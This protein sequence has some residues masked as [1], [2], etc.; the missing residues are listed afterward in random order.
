MDVGT[1]LSQFKKIYPNRFFDVGIAEEH[2]V[3]MSAAMAAKGMLPVCAV[4]S[5]FLQRAYDQLLHDTALNNYHLVMAVDRSGPVGADGPT[6]HG[7]FDTS[8]L[9]SVPGMAVFAPSSY[10]ELSAAARKALYEID[11]PVAIK[12]P[13]G[14]EKNF[15]DNTFDYDAVRLKEGKDVTLI[16]YGIMINTVLDI[17]DSLLGSGISVEVI[18]MNRIDKTDND[19][20]VE[21]VMKTGFAVVCEDCIRAGSAG[22]AIAAMLAEKKIGCK[23]RLFNFGSSFAEVASVEEIFEEH[24]LNVSKIVKEIK[25]ELCK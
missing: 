25:G 23:V 19:L 1:G 18:K 21:S 12:Y 5:T 16:T 9:R 15:K 13:K 20:I 14:A 6:H 17:A 24:G 7:L 3:A 8:F 2:A 11:G 4:Y 22:E 10:A